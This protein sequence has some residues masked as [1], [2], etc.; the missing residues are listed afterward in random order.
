MQKAEQKLHQAQI[1]LDACQAH[2]LSLQGEIAEIQ[3]LQAFPGQT[4]VSQSGG[5]ESRIMSDQGG[6]PPNGAEEHF[7]AFKSV[8]RMSSKSM[9]EPD[10]ADISLN[11]ENASLIPH[12]GLYAY[13]LIEKNAKYPDMLGIDKKNKVYTVEGEDICIVVSD[14]DIYQ[15]QSQVE[16]LYTEITNVTGG[17]FPE[18]SSDLL[19]GHEEVIDRIMQKTTIVPLK[20]GTILKDQE[21]V[22]EMLQDQGENFKHLLVKFKGKVECGLKVYADK[23]ALIQHLVHI[24]TRLTNR[25]E[26]QENLSRGTAYLLGRKR[27]EELNERVAMQFAQVAEAIFRELEEDAIDAKKNTILPQKQTGKKKEMILNAAYLVEMEKV[28]RFCQDGQQLIERYAF[29]KLDLE[30]S[31]PWPPYNFT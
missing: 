13:G 4:P 7:S 15:F 2:F 16:E 12:Y 24:E 17:T 14:I 30:F 18:E 10:T 25:H 1:K 3:S 6:A 5:E 22:A 29:M 11:Q 26:Q 23:Q 21:A 31:G 19:Q 20:F 27:E 28:A 8:D 9:I